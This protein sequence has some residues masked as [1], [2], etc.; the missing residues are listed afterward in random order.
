MLDDATVHL[1]VEITFNM[2][3][4]ETIKMKLDE[5]FTQNQGLAKFLLFLLLLIFVS[6]STNTGCSLNNVFFSKILKY[7]PDSGLSWFPLGVS[8]YTMAGQT[9]ALQQN[10]QSSEKS[11]HFKEKH[12]I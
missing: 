2:A 4:N 10:L 1:E 9:P 11:Q 6:F 5:V 3:F 12:N 8:V 7:I